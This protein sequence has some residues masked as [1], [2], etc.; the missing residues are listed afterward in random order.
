MD[1]EKGLAI[2][3]VLGLRESSAHLKKPKN[4]LGSMAQARGRAVVDQ[5]PY[6]R[7]GLGPILRIDSSVVL[8]TN[9]CIPA[10]VPVCL[11]A[12]F[13]PPLY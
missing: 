7:P 13:C 9:P 5:G 4:G 10:S 6:A 11:K 12:T 8:S 3:S 2:R 1:S